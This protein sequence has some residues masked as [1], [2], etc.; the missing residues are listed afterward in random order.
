M[1]ANGE[2]LELEVTRSRRVAW[3]QVQRHL[4]RYLVADSAVLPHECCCQGVS[5][6]AFIQERTD[7]SHIARVVGPT[8]K[9]IHRRQVHGLTVSGVYTY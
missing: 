7:Q 5:S 2:E 3:S 4:P 8:D 9:E 6:T 1:M